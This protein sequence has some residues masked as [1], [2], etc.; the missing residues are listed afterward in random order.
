MSK[1]G[2]FLASNFTPTWLDT[3]K[4]SALY[5]SLEGHCQYHNVKGNK[6][7]PVRDQLKLIQI[8]IQAKKKPNLY[9]KTPTVRSGIGCGNGVF[10]HYPSVCSDAPQPKVAIL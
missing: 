2:E 7:V 10:K 3:E 8:K 9:N 6:S 4:L 5:G 1:N